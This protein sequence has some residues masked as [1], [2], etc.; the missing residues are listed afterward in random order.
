MGVGTPSFIQA[1]SILAWSN[2]D[3]VQKHRELYNQKRSLIKTACEKT[4]LVVHGGDA[5]FYMWV[6]SNQHSNSEALF[7]WFLEKNILVTPG[8][9]FGK[10]GNPYIRLVFCLKDQTLQELCE[11]L[12]S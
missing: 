9:V 11:N 1:A 10:D 2:D 6:K 3:H 12:T 4:G 5:G 7:K 8:T